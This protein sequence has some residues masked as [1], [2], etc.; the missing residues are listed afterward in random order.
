MEGHIHCSSKEYG[1]ER[2]KKEL[3][4]EKKMRSKGDF[5]LFPRQERLEHTSLEGP[6]YWKEPVARSKFKYTSN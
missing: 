2:R 3:Y 6:S 4:L 5:C 1:N